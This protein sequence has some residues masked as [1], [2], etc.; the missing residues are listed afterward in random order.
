VDHSRGAQSRMFL[1]GISYS[2]NVECGFTYN[3][4]IKK[5]NN[6]FSIGSSLVQKMHGKIMITYF[7]ILLNI[8]LRIIFQLK[9]YYIIYIHII[10]IFPILF[11]RANIFTYLRCSILQYFRFLEFCRSLDYWYSEG[12]TLQYGYSIK[13]GVMSWDIKM[14]VE[15]GCARSSGSDSGLVGVAFKYTRFKPLHVFG[16]KKFQCFCCDLHPNVVFERMDDDTPN[17]IKRLKDFHKKYMV[18]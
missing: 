17:S 14:V 16:G 6:Y 3:W 5:T 4:D 11:C 2:T 13:Y 18:L 12:T 7:K 8:F 9:V 1:Y 15:Y 10:Y